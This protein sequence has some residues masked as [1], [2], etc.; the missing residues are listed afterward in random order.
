MPVSF[1]LHPLPGVTVHDHAICALLTISVDF[2]M[3]G[4]NKCTK[5]P[6]EQNQTEGADI[7]RD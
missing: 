1:S 5:K 2:P 4:Q 7:D 3:Y 6:G